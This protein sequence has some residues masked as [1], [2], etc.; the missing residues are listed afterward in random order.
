MHWLSAE[1][2]VRLDRIRIADTCG[3]GDGV[4]FFFL[5]SAEDLLSFAKSSSVFPWAVFD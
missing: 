1:L 2:P 4:F 3:C 5:T